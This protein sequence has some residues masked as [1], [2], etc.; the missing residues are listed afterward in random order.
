MNV[1]A[2]KIPPR[3][4]TEKIGRDILT[5]KFVPKTLNSEAVWEWTLSVHRTYSYQGKAATQEEARK[6]ANKRIKAF[7]ERDG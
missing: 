2:L 7:G 1:T 5:L 4:I 6:E 3:N